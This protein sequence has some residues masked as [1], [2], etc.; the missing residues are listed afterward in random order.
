[1]RIVHAIVTVFVFVLLQMLVSP[2]IA[3]GDIAPDF[4]LLLV[5]YFAIQ[6]K[7]QRAAVAGFVIGLGQDLF[8]PELLGL[9][10][11]TKSL[12]GYGF[13]LVGSKA[14]Q[15]HPL[16]LMALLG[17]AAVAHDFVYL[18]FFSGLHL[19]KF[20]I[21]WTTVSIPSALYTAL[22]GLVVY[23][24]AATLGSKAVRTLGKARS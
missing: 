19:G 16:L 12:V 8:N 9:N 24:I 17:V 15:D 14:E 6:R 3:I 11:L 22:T 10:A 4:I 21:L 23:K 7:P 13:G 1:M 2:K 5:A 20:I 18:L